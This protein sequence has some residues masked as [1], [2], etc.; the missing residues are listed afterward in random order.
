MTFQLRP[1]QE[2]AINEIYDLFRSGKGHVLL[3]MVMGAAKTATSCSM[4]KSLQDCKVPTQFIVKRRE[5]INQ[6]SSVF[7]SWGIDH[8]VNMASHYKYNPKK[9]IQLS[10]VD[11]LRARSFYPDSEVVFIDEWQ[12][13]NSETYERIKEQQRRLYLCM[14]ILIR[15]EH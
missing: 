6:T 3:Y 14:M 15:F 2:S 13:A 10:S 8:G 5:L 12:D 11:T 7:K 9:L 1:Y 4:I